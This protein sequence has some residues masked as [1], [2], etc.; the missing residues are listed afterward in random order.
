MCCFAQALAELRLRRVVVQVVVGVVV[1]QVADDEAGEDRV[2]GG[3]PEDQREDGRRTAPRAGCWPPGGITSRSRSFGWSWWTP[4]MMKW[5][6]L[7]ERVVGLPVEDLPVQPVL[8]QRPDQEAGGDQQHDLAA[9]VAAVGAAATSRRRS[10]G[11]K[12]S[13]GHGGVDPREEVE[14]AALEQRRRGAEAGGALVC[15]GADSSASLDPD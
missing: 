14:E 13:A 7:P 9:P 15:H 12:I 11:T 2:G 3:S 1:D 4:W 6:R 10:P 5:R 8:G